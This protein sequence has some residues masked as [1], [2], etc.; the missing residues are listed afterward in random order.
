V[1]Y[2]M[3]FSIRFDAETEKR[4]RRLSAETGRPRAWLVREA[5]EQY[6]AARERPDAPRQ[7]AY[8][9]LKPYGTVDSGGAN[10]SV[11]THRKYRESLQKKYRAKRSR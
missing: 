4:I 8:D 2:I 10:D 5:V 3:P 11:D 1:Y 7:T 9:R 6:A